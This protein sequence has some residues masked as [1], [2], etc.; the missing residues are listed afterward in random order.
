[1]VSRMLKNKRRTMRRKYC[2]RM[3]AIA[4]TLQGGDGMSEIRIC[5]YRTYTEI[6]PAILKG[7]GDVT[8]TGFMDCLREQCPAFRVKGEY[9]YRLGE[10][11]Y[12]EHCLRLE[13]EK[14]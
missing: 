8:V 14:K 5:P 2:N 1:M 10:T 7:Q 12:T 4:R 13:G 9:S 3:D 6:R 11:E